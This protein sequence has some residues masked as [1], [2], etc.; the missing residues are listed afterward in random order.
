MQDALK[1]QPAG[2]FD[3]VVSASATAKAHG[4]AAIAQLLTLAKPGGS[5]V[6][7]E[8]VSSSATAAVSQSRDIHKL[9]H[10][11]RKCSSRFLAP[12]QAHSLFGKLL[13]AVVQD[14]SSLEKLQQQ[15]LLGGLTQGA[16]T[17]ALSLPLPPALA[18]IEGIR[19]AAVSPNRSR[20]V[21]SCPFDRGLTC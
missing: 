20:P 10:V 9:Q 3:V 13:H 7:Q 1:A 14:V 19:L 8:P 6:L 5:V 17:A 12:P 15:A 18:G 4:S 21:A 11:N 16:T 2:M